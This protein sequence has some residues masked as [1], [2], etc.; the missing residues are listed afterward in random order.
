[1][2]DLRCTTCGDPLLAGRC[3]RCDTRRLA[4]FV[5]REVVLLV[6]L[7]AITVGA[8]FLTRAAAISN[9]ALG[10]R[11]AAAWFERAERA[12]AAGSAE[13]ALAALRRAVMKDPDNREYRLALAGELAA[14]EQ[15]DEAERVLGTLREA[16]VE[17]PDANLQL[18][19]LEGQ[20]SNVDVSRRYYQ[21]ALA[22]VWRP[23]DA[24]RRRGVR[25][26]LIDFLLRHGERAR[27]LS[28]LLVMT[29]DLPAA[30]AVQVE[31][32]TRLLRA[33]D[34]GLALEYFTRVLSDDADHAEA[35]AGAG[36]AAFELGDYVRA[37]RY[38]N[39]APDTDPRTVDL[40]EVARLVLAAD[41]LETRIGADARR[42][43]A[44][45]A[46]ER[47]MQI[48]DACVAEAPPDRRALLEPL[49]EELQTFDA[50]F[51]TRSRRDPRDVSEEGLELAYRVEVSVEQACGPSTMPLDR[52]LL[53]IG[54]RHGFDRR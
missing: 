26:E 29:A 54:R 52:A 9:E 49:Q 32:G 43:R 6:V 7:T 12:R 24:D 1:M 33:G 8:F 23:E 37:R 48:L 40:R 19:R 3:L 27:A 47:A 10:R 50:T 41:P 2:N 18:A 42:T 4:T 45:A 15:L 13:D 46:V 36:A 51:V 38:L 21:S 22:G 11:D 17:D 44:A 28:E 20:R 14:G 5:H 39:A 53:L 31:V 25:L 34:P 30:P 16:D 35:L